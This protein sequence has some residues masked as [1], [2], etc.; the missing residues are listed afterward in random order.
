M[1][2]NL[3]KSPTYKSSKLDYLVPI[4]KHLCSSGGEDIIS[5]LTKESDLSDLEDAYNI[6]LWGVWDL[7][8][9]K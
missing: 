5:D 7:F 8:N 1:K 6:S 4:R 9:E 3:L 2:N